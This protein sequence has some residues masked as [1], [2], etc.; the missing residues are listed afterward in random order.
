MKVDNNKKVQSYPVNSN[1][2]IE[3]DSIK[4]KNVFEA[5]KEFD[6]DGNG[7]LENEEIAGFLEKNIPLK[8]N[9]AYSIYHET[10]DKNG[11]V[12]KRCFLMKSDNAQMTYYFKNGKPY[13]C[14]ATKANG[15]RHVMNLEN[16]KSKLYK[17][18]SSECGSSYVLNEKNLKWMKRLGQDK[19]FRFSNLLEE[20]TYRLINNDWE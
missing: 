18:G 9:K 8:S 3:L 11:Q 19:P 5:A 12:S 6:A 15:D 14:I 10:K 4:K 2:A 16:G 17:N 20:L 1:G 7:I 13:K